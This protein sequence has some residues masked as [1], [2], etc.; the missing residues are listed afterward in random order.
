MAKYRS[1]AEFRKALGTLVKNTGRA[2]DNR[3]RF[4]ARKNFFWGKPKPPPFPLIRVMAPDRRDFIIGSQEELEDVARQYPGLLGWRLAGKIMGTPV[5]REDSDGI[6]VS[7]YLTTAAARAN[8]F[9]SKQKGGASSAAPALPFTVNYDE[10]KV[11]DEIPRKQGKTKTKRFAT[12]EEIVVWYQG[13]MARPHQKTVNVRGAYKGSKPFDITRLLFAAN[14]PRYS[15][16]LQFPR[17]NYEYGAQPKLANWTSYP[18]YSYEQFARANR[19]GVPVPARIASTPREAAYGAFVFPNKAPGSG[20]YPIGDLY[21]ARLALVYVLSP[22]NKGKRRAVVQAVQAVH[23]QYDW[24]KWW[25]RKAKG[26]KGVQSW[27]SY[28]KGARKNP[29][30]AG[31]V[32]VPQKVPHNAGPYLPDM[33]PYGQGGRPA[34]YAVKNSAWN[35]SNAAEALR[36]MAKGEGAPQRYASVI[37]RMADVFPVE[38]TK[39]KSLWTTYRKHYSAISRHAKVPTV[40]SLRRRESRRAR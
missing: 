8:F 12:A 10:Y 18:E 27:A 2:R 17:Q 20:S 25:D 9:W 13:E 4:V 1:K 23:P 38:D 26:K 29:S 35:Q 6:T 32:A 36:L 5:F 33:Y 3:G 15:I 22:S 37:R 7:S 14:N 19:G 16:P 11:V 21:H 28:V 24:A 34:S 39:H 40:A 31:A 30:A